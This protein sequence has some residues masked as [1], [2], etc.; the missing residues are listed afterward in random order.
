[1]ANIN[2]LK[3]GFPR[4]YIALSRGFTSSHRGIDMCWNSN[5]GGKYAPVFAPADGTVVALRDGM[6]NTWKTDKSNWGNY[7]KIKHADGIYTLMAHLLKGSFVVKVGQKVK[8][9][10]TLAQM[11]N[12][13]A[14][15]G[16]H[17]HFEVYLNGS[18]TSKRVDPLKYCYAYPTDTV[19]ASTQKEYGILR[20]NPV[21]QCGTPVARNSAV[22][23]IKVTATTL[24]AR[25]QAGLNGTVC[26]YIN[27]GIY[28]V[29][30]IC[31]VDGY[32]WYNV[33][34]YWIANNK[35]QTWCEFLPKTEPKFTLS[36]KS[37]STEQKDAMVAWCVSS[38]V[39]YSVTEE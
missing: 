8:R 32:T 35:A 1:M 29:H 11:D 22:D 17:V 20:Y 30:G 21:K 23:Q 38:D 27:V 9:G 14:S 37:L 34:E 6:G 36:M 10:Q 16:C 39:D 2:D 5:Y 13:G 7:I 33:D 28:D 4:N 24:R 15:T 19:N 26:G 12:S 18:S 3:L 25:S 31:E